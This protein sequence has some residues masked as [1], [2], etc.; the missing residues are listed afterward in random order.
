MAFEGKQINFW[1]SFISINMFST[2]MCT[3]PVKEWLHLDHWPLNKRPKKSA[4]ALLAFYLHPQSTKTSAHFDSSA[5]SD[6]SQ[7]WP[8]MHHCSHFE[9]QKW[10]R[11]ID[12]FGDVPTLLLT[13][14]RQEECTY[15]NAT[16]YF[17]LTQP[18]NPLK[19]WILLSTMAPVTNS[20]RK[21]TQNR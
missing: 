10:S 14:S 11:V 13:Y 2:T 1:T 3:I 19:I 6:S 5:Q 8:C 12:F 9:G 20:Q 4:H 18:W 15:Y 7:L 17:V 21:I 16:I